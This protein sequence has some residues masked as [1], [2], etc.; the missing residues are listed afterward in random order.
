MGHAEPLLVTKRGLGAHRAPPKAGVPPCKP[1]SAAPGVTGRPEPSSGA[2]QPLRW[3]RGARIQQD[4]GLPSVSILS[5]TSPAS[6]N[7]GKR[8]AAHWGSAGCRGVPPHQTKRVE[9][10]AELV[11]GSCPSM[12]SLSHVSRFKTGMSAAD[13]DG[14]GMLQFANKSQRRPVLSSAVSE[15][16][17]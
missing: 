11:G 15:K 8:G 17:V 6:R 10:A 16:R 5:R 2:A 12:A 3:F 14:R 4:R 1:S 7:S 13:P 9:G